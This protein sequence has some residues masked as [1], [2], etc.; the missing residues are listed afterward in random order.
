MI[1]VKSNQ[2]SN[3]IIIIRLT[4]RNQKQKVEYYTQLMHSIKKNPLC[5]R[6]F[7]QHPTFNQILKIAHL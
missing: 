6:T 2:F 5:Q 4:K 7:N 1:F 3:N